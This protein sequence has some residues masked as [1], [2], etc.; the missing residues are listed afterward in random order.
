MSEQPGTT[1]VIEWSGDDVSGRAA[2]VSR[3]TLARLRKGEI[4]ADHELDLHGLRAVEAERLVTEALIAARDD[5]ARCV[6]VI[7]GQGHRSEA[8]PVLKRALPR[9]LERGRAARFVMAFATPP[10]RHGGA[11][12]TL[13]LL[14]RQR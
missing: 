7:H 5:G 2:D 8:G 10:A 3:R 6:S 11:G 9:W 14:R 12:V 1:F 4:E 13:V